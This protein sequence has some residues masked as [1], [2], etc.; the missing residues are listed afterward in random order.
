MLATGGPGIV[1]GRSTNS[2]IN[3]GT[4]A[5]RR[6]P[7]GR[8]L[9]QRR[10][11]PGPP[12]RHPRRGQAAADVRVGARRGRPGLGARRR[13]ATPA[14]RWQIPES[15]RWYFLEE[16]YPRYGNLVPR[17]IATREIFNVCRE[18]GMG[19]GGQRRGL[20]RRHAHPGRDARREARGHP[21]DL[22]EVRRR[23]PAHEPDE[24]LPGRALLDGRPVGRLRARAERRARW[25][26]SPR[27]QATNIP[28]L[29]AVGE[30]TT[31]PRRQP[32][33]RQLA[34]LV[35]LRRHDRRPG[36][37][38]ATRRTTPGARPRCR[39]RSSTARRSEWAERFAAIDKMNGQREPVPCSP[40]ELGEMMTENVT[41]VRHNDRL[42]QDAARSST[43]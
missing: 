22:R 19:I 38:R 24:D 30:A 5:G 43:S 3:T 41:V 37:G 15:E 10:V 26:R 4:A 42:A 8:D 18:L 7:A 17:D 14:I 11:H 29:Y 13:R 31:V 36:D 32:P 27:N 12:H 1:F 9:R 20:P 16:K 21:R 39:R 25:R 23:R 34:A 2:I 6:V 40:E 28:G 33:R 35:H